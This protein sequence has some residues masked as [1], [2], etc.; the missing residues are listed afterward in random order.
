MKGIHGVRADLITKLG[1]NVMMDRTTGLMK[2]H[3]IHCWVQEAGSLQSAESTFPRLPEQFNDG[4][5]WHF[6]LLGQLQ[7]HTSVIVVWA[8]I[9]KI[10]QMGG[11]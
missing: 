8:A 1:R 10:P 9:A 4:A 6:S 3:V 7:L 11:L 2:G 5:I